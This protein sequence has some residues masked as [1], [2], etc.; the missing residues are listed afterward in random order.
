M[1]VRPVQRVTLSGADGTVFV[2]DATMTETYVNRSE[3]T[4]HP[5][6]RGSNIADHVIRQSKEI[7]FEV[8]QSNTPIDGEERDASNPNRMQRFFDD[9]VLFKDAGILCSIVTGAV[10]AQTNVTPLAPGAIGPR[11]GTPL[12]GGTASP[13][14][15]LE[16]MTFVQQQLE[17]FLITG[18]TLRR[19][20][21]TGDAG[22]FTITLRQIRI[23]ES[24]VVFV[25]SASTK[26]QNKAKGNQKPADA[27][28]KAERAKTA[29]HNAGIAIVPGLA[30]GPTQ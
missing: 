26:L 13:I 20:A 5:T 24:Q 14:A 19:D 27:G 28:N 8:C 7:T 30:N 22:D 1:S 3:V 9:V 4:E 21:K 10:Q 11:L 2:F 16:T 15:Q 12:G 23:V 29:A 25:P 17:N 6:E 18:V